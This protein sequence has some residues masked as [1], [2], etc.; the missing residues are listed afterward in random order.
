MKIILIVVAVIIFLIL[1]AAASCAY[2]FY[3]AKQKVTQ[4]EKQVQTSFPSRMGTREVQ[5][6]PM[7]PP[8][9]PGGFPTRG[10]GTTVDM[11]DLSYPGATLGQGGNQMIPGAGG[12][13][14]Q[15]YLTGDSVDT[16]MAYYKGK[17]G[18]NAIVTQSGGNAVLQVGGTGGLTSISIVSDSA[19]GKTKITITS[20]GKQ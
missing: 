10:A 6:Q 15:E 20:I 9:T 7:A 19:S 14:V 13:K 4:F 16:V 5:P 18:A 1:L 11:G 12:I 2:M 8:Q 17:L 3:R